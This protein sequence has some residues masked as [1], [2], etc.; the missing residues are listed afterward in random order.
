MCVCVLEVVAPALQH[1]ITSEVSL[2]K[3]LTQTEAFSV[4]G[5]CY[6]THLQCVCVCVLQLYIFNRLNALPQCVCFIKYTLLCIQ[7]SDRKVA[8][9]AAAQHST[10]FFSSKCMRQWFEWTLSFRQQSYIFCQYSWA[11]TPLKCCCHCPHTVTKSWCSHSHKEIHYAAV[12]AWPAPQLVR[13]GSAW[14]SLQWSEMLVE[15]HR[16]WLQTSS[17]GGVL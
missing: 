6:C 12:G 13:S 3:T 8:T 4:K 5:V 15:W 17:W 7:T 2:K 11:V 10:V 14:G 9:I 16:L 1:V